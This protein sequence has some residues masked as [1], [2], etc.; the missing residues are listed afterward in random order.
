MV[1]MGT[2]YLGTMK[3]HALYFRDVM[4]SVLIPGSAPLAGCSAM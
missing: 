3:R 2:Q 4:L 1:A